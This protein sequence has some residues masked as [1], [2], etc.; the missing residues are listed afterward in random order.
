MPQEH[1]LL[2]VSFLFSNQLVC[3]FCGC[4]FVNYVLNH[5]LQLFFFFFFLH[6]LFAMQTSVEL[7]ILSLNV[8]GIRDQIKKSIFLFLKDFK[9]NISFLKDTSSDLKDRII[10]KKE[11]GGEIFFFYG[12]NNSKGF[13]ILINPTIYCQVDCCYSNKQGEQC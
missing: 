5:Y 4:P 11:W 9:A 10:W 1:S 12:I 8:R 6:H 13:F 3:C 7:D 2:S